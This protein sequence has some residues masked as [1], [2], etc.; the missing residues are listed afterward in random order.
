MQKSKEPSRNP[1]L[2]LPAISKTRV[3]VSTKSKY[4][5]HASKKVHY[6]SEHLLQQQQQKRQ[7]SHY[8]QIIQERLSHTIQLHQM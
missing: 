4:F 8:Q 7:Y 5:K 2:H 1:E 6:Q 3:K